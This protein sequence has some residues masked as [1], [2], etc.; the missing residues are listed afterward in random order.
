MFQKSISHKDSGITFIEALF[1][2]LGT[3]SQLPIYHKKLKKLGTK[4]GTVRFLI[5]IFK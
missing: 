2:V 3:P 4:L 5:E 1:I